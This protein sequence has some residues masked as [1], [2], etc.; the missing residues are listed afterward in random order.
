M[1]IP[2]KS[3]G[4]KEAIIAS[5]STPPALVNNPDE[6]A[7]LLFN[8]M[9][10]Y[11]PTGSRKTSQIGVF[12][13]YIYEKLGKVTRLISMD[14]G[15]W[16][17]IQDL[18]NAGIIEAWRVVEEVNPKVALNKAS[19]G[20]W[21][22]KIVNGLRASD[23]LQECLPRD[24]S[25]VLAHVG[26]Y[27]IEGWTS[28]ASAVM[29]DQV[30]KGIG[31]SEDVVVPYAET[32]DGKVISGNDYI[33]AKKLGSIPEGAEVFASPSRSHYNMAQNY[34][35]D[36]I[37]NF[38]ALPAE[39]ILYT[40]LEGKG[41]EKLTKTLQYGPQVAGQAITA[42]IP[43]YVGD[44]L[45][46]EDYLKDAG[47]DSKNP[48]QKLVELGIRVW[49][50]QHPDS[51]NGV[52]WPAKARIVPSKVEEF[53]KRMG[54]SGYF[55]L[56]KDSDLGTYLRVQDEMLASSTDEIIKWK[57]EIDAKRGAKNV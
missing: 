34:I 46:F 7:A 28:I 6:V 52:M 17:P 36:L 27:A 31:G 4:Q 53:K 57:E 9:V 5:K 54:P 15:G 26:A 42:T 39:R 38:G 2:L 55:L 32:I 1:G 35:L 29:R 10:I 11:G 3:Q 45:H 47:V 37:R 8:T 22:T 25:R 33:A 41:E 12:A 51:S 40:A 50:T 43:T 16:G 24:R 14:G 20:A 19:K 56:G 44:C 21:P 23:T 13:K 30:G 18:I 49:F 48:D